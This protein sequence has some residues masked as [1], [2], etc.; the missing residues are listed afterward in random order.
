[1][2]YPDPLPTTDTNDMSDTS[3]FVIFL[4]TQLLLPLGLSYRYCRSKGIPTQSWQAAGLS[5]IALSVA[6]LFFVGLLGMPAPVKNV[7]MVT[8]RS[9][10]FTCGAIGI[11]AG[12]AMGYL[13]RRFEGAS[14][15]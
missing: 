15:D 8:D 7:G 3:Q 14:D 5:L 6:M 10:G 11:F 2:Q 13:A 9:M 12:L 1:M 4:L